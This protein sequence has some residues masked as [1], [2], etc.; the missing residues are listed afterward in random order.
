MTQ[1]DPTKEQNSIVC[2]LWNDG[3]TKTYLP[4]HV[5]RLADIVEAHMSIPYRFICVTDETEGFSDKVELF[6][7]PESVAWIKDV[8]TPEKPRL[9]SS[10]RRLWLFSKEAKCLGDRILQTDIDVVILK[11]LAELFTIPDDFV[12][13]RPRSEKRPHIRPV[14]GVHRIGGG[15]WLLRTGTHTHIWEN[16]ST[17]G[18]KEARAAG[19][20]GSDQAWLSYNLAAT[21]KV[22]PDSMGIYHSQDGAKEWTKVPENARIVHFNGN[23]CPWEPEAQSRPWVC[24]LLGVPYEPKKW[25]HLKKRLRRDRPPRR[26]KYLVE[27]QERV[28]Q[29]Y[30]ASMEGVVVN[31]ILYWWGKWPNG[32]DSLG[33]KYIENLVQGIKKNA[34]DL[35]YRIVLFSDESVKLPGVETRKLKVPDDLKWNLKKMFMYSPDSGIEGPSLCLDLD[36]VIVNDLTP[37]VSMVVGMNKRL[38]ITCAGAYRKKK[39]GGS[40]VGFKSR[41]AL[42]RLLWIPILDRQKEI[43]LATNGSERVYYR[44][45]L[46]KKAVGFWDRLLPGSVVSYKRNCKNGIPEGASI[47]RFHGNP[48]PHRVKDRWMKDYW[49]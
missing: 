36:C 5:N 1:F 6:K 32:T 35:K 12:G 33:R 39:A 9:P 38:M 24:E 10:Y 43:E 22:F 13:W 25:A 15:T 2:F 17:K 49:S 23:I 26:G 28:T 37:L 7:L 20:R 44:K 34:G 42:T 40:V 47:I 18:I 14:E 8:R 16:F 19:W 45:R 29:E 46:E 3:S 21:C 41:E 4:K 27:Y 30:A 31:F 11:D 48:R